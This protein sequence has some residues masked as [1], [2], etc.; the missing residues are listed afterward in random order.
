M[1]TSSA[2][3]VLPSTS[4]KMRADTLGISVAANSTKPA[5]R[6]IDLGSK[7]M[8]RSFLAT[9]SLG[10]R[11]ERNYADSAEFCVNGIQ[12]TGS[13]V[14]RWSGSSNK[15]QVNSIYHMESK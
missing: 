9:V 4:V 14:W 10:E 12:R 8:V 11:S 1:E 6:T 13:A 7:W 5:M 3:T 2:S 15:G